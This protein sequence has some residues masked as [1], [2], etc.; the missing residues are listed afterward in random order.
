MLDKN[1]FVTMCNE[2]AI[3]S[4]VSSL[5]ECYLHYEMGNN[6]CETLEMLYDIYIGNRENENVVIGVLDILSHTDIMDSDGIAIAIAA[7]GLYS[8]NVDIQDE[9]VKCF[10]NWELEQGIYQLQL[11]TTIPKWLTEYRDGVIQDLKE[12]WK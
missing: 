5:A 11:M 2:Q 7:N 4:G 1:L 3:E 6:Q 8:N 9:A 10:E 12:C